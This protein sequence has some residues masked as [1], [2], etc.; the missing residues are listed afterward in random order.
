MLANKLENVTKSKTALQAKVDDQAKQLKKLKDEIDKLKKSTKAPKHTPGGTQ[1]HPPPTPTATLR[2]N[3]AKRCAV[4]AKAEPRAP[5]R[6]CKHIV[7]G[8]EQCDF[9]CNVREKHHP[10]VIFI[11][12]ARAYV[13]K[14]HAYALNGSAPYYTHPVYTTWGVVGGMP[15]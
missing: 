2:A 5:C 15:Y 10:S 6:I 11:K 9:V 8:Y 14:Q 7:I 3:S 4:S 1:E 13:N 12:C